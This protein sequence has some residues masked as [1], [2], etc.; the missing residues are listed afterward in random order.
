FGLVRLMIERRDLLLGTGEGGRVRFSFRPGG[1]ARLDPLKLAT[2][3]QRSRGVYRLTP[4]M[5]L[6][7]KIDPH[8]KGH[9]LISEAKKV[10]RDLGACAATVL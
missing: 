5:K 10:L 8:L 1:Q 6:V 4:E 2:L 9:H 3:V 7:V